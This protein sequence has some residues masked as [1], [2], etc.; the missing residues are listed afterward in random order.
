MIEIARV[1]LFGKREQ[2][3]PLVVTVAGV[4]VYLLHECVAYPLGH[5]QVSRLVS[6]S[7]PVYHTCGD[8]CEIYGTQGGWGVCNVEK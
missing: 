6:L 7:L 3:S 5:R 2:A 8:N 1:Q 4:S